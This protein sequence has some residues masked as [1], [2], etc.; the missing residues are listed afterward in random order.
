MKRT[1][2]KRGQPLA[3]GQ[4]LKRTGKLKRG[5]KLR[6]R[7]VPKAFRQRRDPQVMAW[8]HTQ[9]CVIAG[10]RPTIAGYQL[11]EPHQCCTPVEGCHVRS[12]GA[13]G[14][15]RA[16]LVSMCRSMHT[17]QHAIGIKSFQARWGVDLKAEAAEL[18]E[19]Y[20]RET[21]AP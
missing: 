6:A 18:F 12:R 10:R 7:R 21:G 4:P 5:A 17:Q 3:R 20:Q 13:G 2:L 15:D 14:D 1:P 19:R 9:P 11:L 8:I 16:N